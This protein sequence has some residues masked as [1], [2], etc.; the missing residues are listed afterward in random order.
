MTIPNTHWVITVEEDPESG[1]VIL[2]FPQDFL[3]Q[4]GW[5]EGDTIEWVE[6]NDGS[7]IIKKQN[8]E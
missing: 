5:S 3:D 1:D 4:V 2:P 6:N 7:Y 8:K